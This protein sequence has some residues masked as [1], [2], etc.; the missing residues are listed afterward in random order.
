M[1]SDILTAPSLR[2]ERMF[3]KENYTHPFVYTLVIYSI[4]FIIKKVLDF[5]IGLFEKK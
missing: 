2:F 3:E 4:F 1:H 5:I